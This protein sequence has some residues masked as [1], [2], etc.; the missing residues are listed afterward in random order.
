MAAIVYEGGSL[1][2]GSLFRGLKF[3]IGQR[4]PLREHW[5]T[6]VKANGGEVVKLE[7][8]ADYLIA[9]P[10]RPKQAI[11]GSLSY[12]F[13]ENSLKS[14]ELVDPD[15]HVIDVAEESKRP[16]GAGNSVPK[17]NT[18]TKFTKEDD[19]FLT[20]WVI[21][22][23]RKGMPTRGNEL[24]Q[25]LA[26][27]NPRHT[28]QSW[29]DRWIK[30]L[31]PR[32]GPTVFDEDDKEEQ[33]INEPSPI[34][35]RQP[36]SKPQSRPTSS[37]AP[38]V[39]TK[40]IKAPQTKESPI[41]M[42][43]T[44]EDTALLEEN[45]DD[46]MNI[47]EDEE[48][49][50]WQAW[51]DKYHIHTAQQWRNYFFE[52]VKPRYEEKVLL[53]AEKKNSDVA[54]DSEQ[55]SQPNKLQQS[56]A[57]ELLHPTKISDSEITHTTKEENHD[58]TLSDENVFQTE[59]SSFAQRFEAEVNFAP[60][61]SGRKIPL[62]R[63]WQTV[64][65]EEFNGFDQVESLGQWPK[66]AGKLN[67]NDFQHSNAPHELRNCYETMLADFEEFRKIYRS[68]FSWHK[69]PSL[70]SSQEN[71]LIQTQ[72]MQTVN[73]ENDTE[74]GEEDDQEEEDDD[75]D[76]LQGMQIAQSSSKKRRA[77]Q[78][79]PT[80]SSRSH[81][82]RQR[83]DKAKGRELEIPS[84]PEESYA[85]QDTGSKQKLSATEMAR[86]LNNEVITVSSS[87]SPSSSNL[88][89]EDEQVLPQSLS[90]SRRLSATPPVGEP[91]TQDFRFAN[92]ED[93]DPDTP[94]R[95]EHAIGDLAED[96]S[97]QSQTESQKALETQTF[98]EYWMGLGYAEEIVIQA[99]VATSMET[100]SVGLF[101]E[102]LANGTGLPEDMEGVWTKADDEA[103]IHGS[104]TDYRRLWQGPT[105]APNTSS[106]T[107]LE[108]LS[109]PGLGGLGSLGG[110]YANGPFTCWHDE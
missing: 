87:V 76:N 83:I 72:L 101:L 6:S 109:I 58:P 39:S 98:I 4:V 34:T 36:S 81:N 75:L 79:S 42:I 45:Y 60:L 71:N 18:R 29:R 84:T 30:I 10:L 7:K 61:I 86:S 66:V 8:Q 3:F 52:Y 63:L 15:Q 47:A 40:H 12:T 67:F 53:A 49:N 31:E 92:D 16:V 65:S 70:T 106:L 13:L 73:Q 38:V 100:D 56:E 19:D 80:P 48:L 68:K 44:D 105:Q 90:L 93:E 24:Y 41:R 20:K 78:E 89:N 94:S 77:R 2:G 26:A 54:V 51:A 97:T 103:L 107:L 74:G 9:D 57:P 99:L 43:F 17:R 59:L 50:A 91:E 96:S 82:K 88:G 62:F 37:A 110:S 25:D 11:A 5:V 21:K 1:D 35:A 85:F 23:E 28:F 102:Q 69:E 55:P 32:L 22:A 27:K 104:A 64:A 14:G 46:I 95:R 108:V 33:E